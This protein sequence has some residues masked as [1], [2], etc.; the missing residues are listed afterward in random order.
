MFH[1]SAL[2]TLL[3]LT[4][5]SGSCEKPGLLR[6]KNASLHGTRQNFVPYFPYLVHNEIYPTEG[7]PFTDKR[8]LL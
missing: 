5:F 7:L 3:V 8:K 2:L 1:D 4:I 6:M